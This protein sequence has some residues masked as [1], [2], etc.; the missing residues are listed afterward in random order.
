M[1][2][3]VSQSFCIETVAE[4]EPIVRHVPEGAFS[5]AGSQVN[6]TTHPYFC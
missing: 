5:W 2:Y 1:T 3:S 4:T 6:V